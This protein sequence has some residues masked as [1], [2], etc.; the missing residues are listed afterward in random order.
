MKYTLAEVLKHGA[1]NAIPS[2]ELCVM[3]GVDLRTLNKLV[4]DAR[5]QH[6]PVCS[7]MSGSKTGLFLGDAEE[8]ERTC[9]QLEHRALTSLRTRKNLR[10]CLLPQDQQISFIQE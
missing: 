10:M 4:Q 8:I 9:R 7:S 2:S 6:I 1:E 3:L 5:R